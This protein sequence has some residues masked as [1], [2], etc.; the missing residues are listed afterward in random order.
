MLLYLVRHG[1]AG[2][3]DDIRWPDDTL[4]PLTKSGVRK[5][6]RAAR[7]IGKLAPQVDL[8]LSSPSKRAWQTAEILHKTAGWPVPIPAEP[9]RDSMPE[10]VLSFLRDH[11][12]HA[13]VALVGHEPY[14]GRLASAIVTPG[15]HA[16]LDIKK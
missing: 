16:P 2:L 1:P 15:A 7:G 10:A 9:L 12:G 11:D 4:R 6:K 8:V 13:S 14:L 3:R 5:F